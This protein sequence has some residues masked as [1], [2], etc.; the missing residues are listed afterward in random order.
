MKVCVLLLVWIILLIPFYAFVRAG[1]TA[2]QKIR[3]Y[4]EEWDNGIHE[5]I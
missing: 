3:K 1:K 2:D 5:R 4:W